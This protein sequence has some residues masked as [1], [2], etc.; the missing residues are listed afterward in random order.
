[1]IIILSDK[2]YEGVLQGII[3]KGEIGGLFLEPFR[4]NDEALNKYLYIIRRIQ[5]VRET[6]SRKIIH[7]LF[8]IKFSCSM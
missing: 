6:Y 5:A 1:M 4:N 7:R 3:G 8:D 2:L